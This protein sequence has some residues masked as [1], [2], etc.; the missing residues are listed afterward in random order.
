MGVTVLGDTLVEPDESFGVTI[1]SPANATISRA[2]AVATIKD[3]D[4]TTG[5]PT[6]QLSA[7]E[8]NV[9]AAFFL[10]SIEFQQ[11]GYLAYL[12][13]KAA[14]N[15]GERL[16]YR[17]FLG[18]KRQIGG[19]VI[20]GEQGWEDE[21]AANKQAFA[22]LF[23]QRPEFVFNYPQALTPAQFVDAL[24]A[25][26]GD[27]LNPTAGGSLTRAERGQLV[28]DLTSGARTRAQVLLAVAE[29]PEFRRRQS[30]K[31]FVLMQYFGYL[32][33]APNATPDTNFDG[34]NFW[35]SK[36]NQFHGNFIKAEMVKAFITSPEYRQRFGQ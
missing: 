36:L 13:H 15:S 32:R 33:R 7:R 20:V 24:D 29:N 30:S 6:V 3:N 31:A 4:T 21:L 35:L 18:D 27:P 5:T 16:D 17:T 12:L 23:V 22:D 10:L 11:T 14:F 28:A 1:S 9:S 2:S 25:N 26:T 34:Y 19:G 8:F